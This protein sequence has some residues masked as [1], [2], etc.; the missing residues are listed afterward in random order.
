MTAR[1]AG[2]EALR[3]ATFQRIQILRFLAAFVVILFHSNGTVPSYLPG[4]GYPIFS[5]G[6]LGV[7]IFFV[8]SGF[9]ICHMARTR[10]ADW[11]LFLVRR[12]ERI[13]PL[14]WLISG[15]TFV[16]IAVAHVSRTA[17][18]AVSTGDLLRS[19]A[20]VQWTSGPSAPPVIFVGWSLEFEMYFYI[21][22]AIAL[23]LTRRPA[24]VVAGV[25]AAGVAAGNLLF[26]T[27]SVSIAGFLVNPIIL[28]FVLGIVIAQALHDRRVSPWLLAI[29]AL[30]L[31]TTSPGGWGVRVWQGGVP[32]A[33]LVIAAL[34]LDARF[35]LRHAVWRVAVRLGDASYS[36]YLAQGLAISGCCRLLAK[37][38]PTLGA[39]WGIFLVAL[40]AVALGYLC[41]S[42]IERPLARLTRRWRPQARGRAQATLAQ[43]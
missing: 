42:L 17:A 1:S 14:Y 26:P 37:V 32:G 9:I 10:E 16:L 19:L 4:A 15:A 5:Y 31:V 11:R 38:W 41:H 28:E 24:D 30:A 43:E 35:P 23:M 7:D 27:A 2:N 36:L 21:A 22:F 29:V 13:V 25:L 3:G 39:G 34:W 18:G 8:I 12:I 6:Y 33:L 40:L 20:F